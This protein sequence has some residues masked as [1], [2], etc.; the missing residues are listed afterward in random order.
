MA[1]KSL[2]VSKE[3]VL[4]ISLIVVAYLLVATYLTLD[5]P[6]PRPTGN[7][8]VQYTSPIPQAT[9]FTVY[10]ESY[11]STNSAVILNLTPYT[12]NRWHRL[13]RFEYDFAI[14]N[15]TLEPK[16][17]ASEATFFLDIADENPEIT[18]MIENRTTLSIQT[19]FTA[20][21]NASDN[22]IIEIY[23][24]I[25][26]LDDFI[27]HSLIVWADSSVPLC[28]VTIDL[29]STS[30]QSFFEN[31]YMSEMTHTYPSLYISRDNLS[32]SNHRVYP[33]SVN[34]SFY[35]RPGSLNGTCKWGHS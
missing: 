17:Q 34:H 23:T 29:R 35:L 18:Q 26:P 20:A 12:R 8:D 5:Y 27:C 22:W 21:K 15:I 33:R 6:F 3:R 31:P 30:G 4:T 19:N 25:S 7:I 14:F 13:P 10:R 1:L 28:P 32:S 24:H 9:N 16:N 2:R 11:T